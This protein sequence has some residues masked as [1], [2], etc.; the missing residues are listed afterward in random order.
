NSIE[1]MRMVNAQSGVFTLPIIS[2]EGIK[3]L[4]VYSQSYAPV[5]ESVSASVLS[6][7][8][9]TNTINCNSGV[10]N[11]TLARFDTFDPNNPD[12]EI[13]IM[14]D[15]YKSNSTCDVPN[16][17]EGCN[18]MGDED[19]GMDKT[20]FSPLKAILMGDI[21]LRITSG[22]ISVHYVK[23]DLL[24]SGPPDAAFSQDFNGTD[25]SAVW[26]FGSSG[27]E[28]YDYIL[29]SMP[30]SNIVENNQ[31]KMKIPLL[32]DNDFNVFWNNIDNVSSDLVGTDYSDYLNNSYEN[33]LNG[34]G[35]SCSETDENL[36]N[37]LCYKDTENK[38]IW[39]KIPHFTGVGPEVSVGAPTIYLMSP[40][41]NSRT[42]NTL[43]SFTFNF[44]ED[45]SDSANC[46]LYINNSVYGINATSFNY[47]ATTITANPS[48]NEA[49]GYNWW[50]NCTDNNSDEGKSIV[51]ILSIDLTK[52]IIIEVTTEDITSTT[53]TLTATTDE[54]A[55]CAYNIANTSYVSMT[56][57]STTGT[58]S[59]S[60]SLTGLSASTSYT[61]YVRCSDTAGNIMNFSNST[62][63]TTSAASTGGGGGGTPSVTYDEQTF[64]T[65]AAGSTKTVTF[66]KS[67]TLAVT[68][69]TVTVKNKVTNAKIKVDVGSLPSGASAPSSANGSVYKYIT[70]TKTDMTDNDVSKGIIKFKVKMSWLTEKGYGKDTVALHRYYNNKWTKLTTTRD[71]QDTTY[72]YYSA[73]SP[74]FSTFAITAEEAPVTA[75]AEEA[76]EEVPETEENATTEE[77]LSEEGAPA[78]EEELEEEAKS[79]TILIV[80]LIAVVIILAVVG[81]FVWKKKKH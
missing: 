74:G 72:Y 62:T 59:H 9:S 33:Y 76:E 48:L 37:G 55:N 71:S 61:Y 28:I 34:T 47:T 65:L 29:I 69:I 26:K 78:E 27:P 79:N 3:K 42:N 39:M 53:A 7:D 44:T 18:M 10:C 75:P 80:V 14:M 40:D 30:Y 5:S 41:D 1:Y 36:T 51:R 50:I 38:V 31:I 21:S 57:F 77:T 52:P 81:Y 12:E 49:D 20:D 32:Y 13:D 45:I 70:I 6:G 58:T 67:A 60:T 8:S 22:N 63:F 73:E 17:P 46:T 64:G 54:N 24:A 16:P 4:T 19:K 25:S 56:A 43:P 15:F 66:S 2:G 23:T 35:V 68:E 11:I